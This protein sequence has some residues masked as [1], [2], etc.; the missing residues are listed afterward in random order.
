MAP[1]CL[2]NGRGTAPGQWVRESDR[3]VMLLPGPPHELKA[4]FEF[5]C[6][7]RL[8]SMVPKQAI[9]TLVLRIVGMGESDLDQ[10]IAPVYTKYRNPS[11]SILAANGEIQIRLRAR[12]STDAEADSLVAEV[13]GPIESILGD[14]VYSRNDEPLER[15]VGNLL[16]AAHASVAVAESCTGGM[17][18]ERFTTVPGGSD[19]FRGGFIVYTE[20]AKR[21][22]LGVSA[23]T[24]ERFGA[25]SKQAAEAMAAGTR[26]RTG[27]DYALSVTGVAGPGPSEGPG[28]KQIAAGTVYIG[29][30]GPDDS[31][32]LH[33]IFLRRPP[34]NPHFWQWRWRWT[35]CGGA[36]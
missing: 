14:R 27:A 36:C 13:A 5:Q 34:A 10:A 29:L 32:V 23:E 30:A 26:Q 18:G 12:C 24:L 31:R 22:L 4:M 15:V 2:P 11:T 33:R 20:A 1:S 25:V 16:R 7:P 6:L 3:V 17:L 28:G 35:F 21:E 8:A 19:Y 9:R